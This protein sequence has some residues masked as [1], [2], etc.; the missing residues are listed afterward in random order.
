VSG[1]AGHE[2]TDRSGSAQM[3]AGRH[4]KGLIRHCRHRRSSSRS[5]GVAAVPA[6]RPRPALAAAVRAPPANRTIPGPENRCGNPRQAVLSQ[7]PH[8]L[9]WRPPPG[10][11]AAGT[12][13]GCAGQGR[14]DVPSCRPG[15]PGP[16][17]S[18]ITGHTPSGTPRSGP[19]GPRRTPASTSSCASWPR[20]SPPSGSAFRLRLPGNNAHATPG[21]LPAPLPGYPRRDHQHQHRHHRHDQPPRLLTR[22]PRR[23]P[24]SRHH[25]PLA[26]RTPAPLR[27]RLT[28]GPKYRCGNPR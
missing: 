8:R 24:A 2:R 26:G 25:R 3:T 16:G 12:M 20:P 11:A 9:P 15:Q 17:H 6:P 27:I 7:Q 10:R 5:A 4:G 22:P 19:G 28:L 21:T 1:P 14:P 23:R 13:D 18:R